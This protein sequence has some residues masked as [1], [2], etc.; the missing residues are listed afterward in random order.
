MLFE[1][2][3]VDIIWNSNIDFSQLTLSRKPFPLFLSVAENEKYRYFI[4]L[5]H[6]VS[7]HLSLPFPLLRLAVRPVRPG[8]KL[9]LLLLSLILRLLLLILALLGENLL[10]RNNISPPVHHQFISY[11]P[12]P[13]GTLLSL[14]PWSGEEPFALHQPPEQEMPLLPDINI[15]THLTG[16]PGNVLRFL[17]DADSY[18]IFWRLLQLYRWK[19]H[20]IF[21]FCF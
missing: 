17:E 11:L 8:A 20:C 14:S 6:V 15:S 12:S 1:L 5:I 4:Y 18:K 9:T 7:S 3:Y 13:A 16:T 19:V 2:C 10:A 21:L